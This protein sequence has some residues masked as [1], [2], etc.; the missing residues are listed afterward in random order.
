MKLKALVLLSVEWKCL[1]ESPD[2]VECELE[3]QLHSSGKIVNIYVLHR[4]DQ[5]EAEAEHAT[6]G[7][8][9]GADVCRSST[10]RK[11]YVA[12]SRFSRASSGMQELRA[13]SQSPSGTSPA[14]I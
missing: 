4:D 14:E 3:W 2:V 12:I 11:W 13:S 7:L 6:T 8:P 1:I 9:N 10:G 5:G